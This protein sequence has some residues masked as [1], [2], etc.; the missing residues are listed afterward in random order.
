MLVPDE[1]SDEFFACVCVELI[2]GIA[3]TGAK[4]HEVLRIRD[5]VI[6]KF[7]SGS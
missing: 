1:I 6:G 2:A 3:D 7:L 4:S 5:T